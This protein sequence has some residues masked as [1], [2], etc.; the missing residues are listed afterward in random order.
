MGRTDS[1]AERRIPLAISQQN[2]YRGVLQDGDPALYLIGR[3]YR[4]HPVP[5]AR[6]RR[7]LLSCIGNNPVQL[8]VLDQAGGP[9]PDLVPR[10]APEDL[11]RLSAHDADLL[12]HEWNS[13]IV[14]R[15]LARYTLHTCAEG[16]VVGMDVHAHHILLDGGATGLI[17]ADL[18]RYL[19]A[20]DTAPP[21]PAA[22]LHRLAEAHRREAQKVQA[23][24]DRLTETVRRE[25]A[26]EPHLGGPPAS[27]PAAGSARRGMLRES[28]QITGADYQALAALADQQ[29]IPL[30]TL[31][32]AAAVA[33]DADRRHSTDALVVH[34]VDNRFG[35]A[36]LDVATCLVNSVAQP[37]RF[38]A[39]TSV[40]ELAGA[41]D[42]GYV[43]AVRRR[44]FR[45]ELYRRIY[46]TV[47]RAP[48]TEAL[49]LN[50]L[51]QPCA[52]QLLP[53]LDG[54]PVTSDIGPI[55]CPTVAAVHDEPGRTLTVSIWDAGHRQPGT[56]P[57]GTAEQVAEALRS[58][59]ARWEQP[60]AMTV[61]GWS[62]LGPQGTC[63]RRD[64]P[65][66]PP[67]PSAPAWFL[68]PAVDLDTWRRSRGDVEAWLGWLVDAAVEPGTVLVF[69]DD[70]TDKTLDLLI[71]AHLAGCG[72]SVCDTPGELAERA[73]AIAAHAGICA[74]VIEVATTDLRAHRAGAEP[75][76]ITER[77]RSVRDD[78]A[79]ATSLAY[80]MPTSGS[81]GTPK[82]VPIAHG[83][84]A[85]FCRGHREACGWNTGDTVLQCAPL[86]S[87]I[88]V[89]EVFG[90]AQAGAALI[91]SSATRTGNLTQLCADVDRHR[92]TVLDL[93]TAIWQ[94]CCEQPD[95]LAV[96]AGSAVRQVVIGGEAV[97]AAAVDK[98]RSIGDLGH[99]ALI[100]SYGPT[101]TTVVV[102][103]LPL[104][105]PG[106]AG[107]AGV[108]PRVGRPIAP[109]TVFVAFGEIVVVG[110]LVSTGYLGQD[111]T[112]FG[113]VID[114]SGGHRRAFA[115][116]DRVT[117][118]GQ[119][120]AVFAGRKDSVVKLAGSRVDTAA[121]AR[122]IADDPQICDVALEPD[123]T[124]LAVWFVTARTAAGAP[125]PAAAEHIRGVLL[126]TR[127][128]GFVVS[129]IASIPRKP[130][131]KIDS[132]RLPKTGHPS[133]GP[134]TGQA[135]GL[136][137]LWSRCLD[138]EL[139]PDSSLLAEGV[140]SLDLIRIL[141]ATRRYLGRN[142]SLLEV[143]GADSA[144]RLIEHTAEMGMDADTVAEIDSDLA[145]L[146][147]PGH[148]APGS[149]SADSGAVLV[150]GASG[151]LGTGF[152]RAVGRLRESGSAAPVLLATTSTRLPDA[153]PWRA[154]G[155]VDGVRIEHIAPDAI[156]DLIG[157]CRPA[158]VIN[159][160][161]N[162]NVVV[163]YSQLRPANV[164][165]VADIVAACTAHG[166][167]LVQLSTSVVSAAAGAPQVIDPRLAPYPYA[168]SKAV[169]ELI[170]A[171]GA[172]SLDFAL[173]RLPR[174][175]G[176]PH[177]LA[178]SADIL[179]ALADACAAVGAHPAVSLTEE[180]TSGAAAAAAILGM[181]SAPLGRTVTVLHGDAVRYADFLAGFGATELEVH[182][183]KQRLDDSAWARRN[184]R[185]WAVIDAWLTL[186][187]RLGERSYAQ[188]LA[189]YPTLDL[190][191]DAV[192]ELTAAP[193]PLVELV[194][195]G[196]SPELN[197][198]EERLPLEELTE[199][200][201]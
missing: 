173:V 8:C 82:L 181:V 154:L 99:V 35:D 87:D 76:G 17:E 179:V 142:L 90:A 120:F 30:H 5:L 163:P 69:T 194:T 110:Q 125:D 85:L 123:D 127:V 155:E 94:L 124:R 3:S 29:Q 25:L 91:R 1:T 50:Y 183:W 46:L 62:E 192:T 185:R 53:F 138:R 84:L 48:Q 6:F 74:R 9:Y 96:L 109:N 105:G 103:H 177:Q 63:L 78:T 24:H 75:A 10:L 111:G 77:L 79:L 118:D 128:P 12:I 18:G 73:A 60:V 34:A 102:S 26:A 152:A 56:E 137:Q 145:G 81:T 43:K 47:H 32:T 86:T 148:P 172:T 70:H 66:D 200:K 28:V 150:L 106:S 168:A 112:G 16:H 176:E 197:G 83:A 139:Q 101:E 64:A 171:R 51:P 182:D 186:G 126:A 100:S 149:V 98:W 189:D 38:P 115:T 13:S 144:A 44:W 141:P 19:S 191:T 113:T 151:I 58:F 55:E 22:G 42:R 169:A 180:V 146:T 68:D 114:S 37:V 33:V 119:G 188:F 14:G 61:G 167:G 15:P 11:V 7:A 135:S 59:P 49:A 129:A 40:R 95:I 140:G 170:V 20:E 157:R 165:A 162:T 159:A 27:Q 117:F 178:E 23:A 41:L 164:T 4:F 198:P 187:T 121:I 195:G 104:S 2:I 161:G 130:G 158:T 71:A 193:V 132:A 21:D 196:I 131:G 31:V 122:L 72:Y 199:E 39:L 57:T 147:A 166:A 136:A 97:R 133:G 156:A 175:L 201:P 174:V 143:I 65:A 54:P 160:I 93:P 67:P 92:P 134:E 107:D 88:S 108:R 184:P 190:N 80:V 116:A 153:G 45:E 52:A 89:E 36:D